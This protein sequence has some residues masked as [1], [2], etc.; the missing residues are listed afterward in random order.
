MGY[1]F[2]KVR[3]QYLENGPATGVLFYL[4]CAL[5]TLGASTTVSASGWSFSAHAALVSDYVFRGF[6]QTDTDP[7]IQ[8]SLDLNHNNGFYSG[9]WGSNVEQGPEAPVNFDG[10]STEL[11]V[12]LGWKG[13]INSKGLELTARAMRYIYPGTHDRTNNSNEMSLYLGYDFGSVAVRG[14]INYS[15]DFILRVGESWYWDVGV[16]LPVGS[17]NI[18]LHTGRSDYSIRSGYTDYSAGI[19]GEIAGLSLALTYTG[20]NNVPGGCTSRTCGDRTILTITKYF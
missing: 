1:P 12:Y 13:R 3:T 14:G 15:N 9:I 19:S 20:T 16:E 10:A 18:N 2:F 5:F 17:T 7:A 8:G 6:T 11:D 4:L